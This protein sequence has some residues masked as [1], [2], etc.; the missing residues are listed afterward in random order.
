MNEATIEPSAKAAAANAGAAADEAINPDKVRR[1]L[2]GL[3]TSV[4]YLDL[5]AGTY[6][7]MSSHNVVRERI[8]AQGN[9]QEQLNFFARH[10][11]DPAFSDD[12][13]K[14]VDLTTLNERMGARKSLTMEYRTVVISDQIDDR[15]EN[16]WSQCLF[17]EG[18]RNPDGTLAHVLFATQPIHEEKLAILNAHQRLKEHAEE[19]AAT[20]S[21]MSALARPYS[22]LY[23]VD[24]ETDQFTNFRMDRHTEQHYGE[25]FRTGLYRKIMP[26]YVS[27]NVV[28][29]DQHLFEPIMD[30]RQ[31]ADL[32][33]QDPDYSFRYR[34]RRSTG[35]LNHFQ[36]HMALAASDRPEF[37]L[38]F[39]NIDDVIAGEEERRKA[40]QEQLRIIDALSR[41]YHSLFKIYAATN[42]IQLYRTDGE[43]L[44]P[45]LID[46]LVGGGDYSQTIESYVTNFVVDE[47]QQR[48]REATCLDT[49]LRKVP[50][51]GLYKTTFKRRFQGQLLHY[52]LNVAR[53]V[54][55]D[56][57]I[58]FILGMRDANEQ[59][60]LVQ[61]AYDAA[62]SANRAKTDFLA[63]MSHDIRTPMNGI[64][65]MTAIA[66][67]HLDD[68]D[69]VADCLGK[70][71]Q[72]SKHL[73]GLINE[74]LDMSKIESG[75][76]DLVEERFNLSDLLED[77]LNLTDA[78]IKA[79]GHELHVSVSNVRHE[80]VIGD[81]LRIQKVFTNLV[82]NAIKHTPHGGKIRLSLSELPSNQPKLARY[83]FV[84]ED[85]GVGMSPE[86]VEQIFEPFSREVTPETQDVQGTGLGM[87]I[88]RN[89]VRMMGGDIKVQSTLGQGSRFTTVL[90]L[91]LAEQEE[92][93]VANLVDLDV[94]VADDDAYSLE[95][96]CH[97][98]DD[99][100]MCATGVTCG[101]DA[102]Q[103]VVKR[104]RQKRDYFAAILDWRM[105]DMNGV[106]TARA[107]RAEVG[108]DVPI[109][110]ISAYDW[111]NIEA[112]A[113]AAGVNA[114]VSKPLFRSR[115]AR[116]FQK[117]TQ[118][119]EDLL[120]APTEL[121]VEQLG[122][123]LDLSGK[124][125]LMAEDNDLNA[126]VAQEILGTT[127]LQLDRV[128]N[129]AQAVERMTQLPEGH[130]DI[131]LMDVQMPNMNGYDATRAIRALS[132]S[133]Y[134]KVPI[135][136]MT[137]N[138][139][140]EDVLAA[141]SAGLT[142]H[143][144]TPLDRRPLAS[145]LRRGLL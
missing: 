143:V 44:P 37:V 114:F 106:E 107:I 57:S 75:T 62:E 20:L 137:A 131:V 69:R 55:D 118:T 5:N 59:I 123:L 66:A 10:M 84:V 112:E 11:V 1:F 24:Y 142:A 54:E 108:P 94:L 133:Y 140:A 30:A 145:V 23:L 135:V 113:R 78:Q 85:N 19:Q 104:H 74:V 97:L 122:Q 96:C 117:L 136:A 28:P 88:S 49:L 43:G 31:A 6:A 2:D 56:G 83:E 65:G 79:A 70:I 29:E 141:K 92:T 61:T 21:M 76:V 41:E 38:G 120:S 64:I 126:E 102:V 46:Q 34:V 130:Y 138:A 77:L 47:D 144:C 127:G 91:R 103:E 25:A 22:N 12:V 73:L 82:G 4:H 40:E 33:H 63:N 58:T 72:A 119:D 13:L 14:F 60:Q 124:R 81:A 121:P 139:F 50:E 90:A 3:Y 116:T 101:K 105:P 53:T 111:A 99:L 17:I 129:G 8:S 9:S 68:R 7:E 45:A 36:L 80:E 67:A 15:A 51:R 87:P 98:L 93:N 134:K 35:K 110:I 27:Q 100:G 16:P 71:T 95:S 18:N 26:L 39:A 115:L 86:F 132:G 125:A 42:T 128:A 89:I 109:I 52:E 32:L 48:M